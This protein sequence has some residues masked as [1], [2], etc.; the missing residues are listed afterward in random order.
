MVEYRIICTKQ[1]VID[2][3]NLKSC[4][5]EKKAREL[6]KIRRDQNESFRK[7]SQTPTLC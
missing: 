2:I 4:G 5:L 1:A 7:I 6:I 3:K